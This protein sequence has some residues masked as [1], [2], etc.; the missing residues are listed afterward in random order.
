MSV[1]K[2]KQ[3]TSNFMH[4]ASQTFARTKQMAMAKMGKA[5]ETVDIQFN[6]ERDRFFIQ[7]KAIKKLKKRCFKN[8]GII[9][10]NICS[11]SYYC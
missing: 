3:A 2:A 8:D 11:A 5:E 7:Y 9:K 10:R 6:Q 4:K 1:E